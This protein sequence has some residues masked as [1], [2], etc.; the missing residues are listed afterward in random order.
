MFLLHEIVNKKEK[1]SLA[2]WVQK[3]Y[4]MKIAFLLISFYI[5]IDAL[6]L[7]NKVVSS[8]ALKKIVMN[9][10]F[11]A[12]KLHLENASIEFESKWKKKLL[13]DLALDT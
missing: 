12:R 4:S 11:I 1:L 2:L 5:R 13:N 3:P 8:Y 10:K 7:L 6:G 9:H